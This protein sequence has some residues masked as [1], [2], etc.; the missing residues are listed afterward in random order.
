M[1]AFTQ[2]PSSLSVNALKR[3]LVKPIPLVKTEEFSL[4]RTLPG[5]SS[6]VLSVAFSPDGQ[7]LA[8]GSTDKTIKLWKKK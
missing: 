3:E 4:L 1:I 8:S 2:E 5:H 6:R 7:T